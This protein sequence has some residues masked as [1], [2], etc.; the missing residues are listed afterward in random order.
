MSTVESK[1]EMSIKW[2]EEEL[3]LLPEKCIFSKTTES[4]LIADPHFGKAAHF[5]KS[6]VPIPEN[7]HVHDFLKLQQLINQYNPKHVYFLGDLFHSDF[8]SSWDDLET[9]LDYFQDITFHLIKGNHDI[10]PEV[11]YRSGKWQVYDSSLKVGGLLL[12]HEPLSSVPEGVLN[13]CGHIHPG[14]RLKGMGRQSLT[15]A[16]FFLSKNQMI[17]PAFGRFTGLATMKAKSGD[18]AYAVTGKKVIAVDFM[19]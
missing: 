17:L 7:V 15:L 13:L 9:F 11:I 12:S 19:E 16:C 14:I 4:L 10:L 8:N 1:G 3:L 2:K 18:L 6:G 5:R